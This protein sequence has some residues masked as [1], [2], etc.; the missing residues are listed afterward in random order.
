[1][2]PP[3]SS[4]PMKSPVKARSY[5]PSKSDRSKRP[6]KAQAP[7][8]QEL[9]A[10]M[11]TRRKRTDRRRRPA[12]GDFEIPADSD[13]EENDSVTSPDSEDANDPV[14]VRKQNG[15]KASSAPSSRAKL[16]KKPKN[17]RIQAKGRLKQSTISPNKA[18]TPLKRTAKPSLQPASTRTSKAT[19]KATYASRHRNASSN[20]ENRPDD[21][22][23]DTSGAADEDETLEFDEGE[24]AQ[25]EKQR[26]AKELE[27]AKALFADIDDWD[28]EFEDLS[29]EGLVSSSP[30]R[31]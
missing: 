13:A 28:M 8:T 16:I 1:M 27:K 31:R 12:A 21:L 11:P 10:L 6:K 15:R 25:K 9:Q 29:A 14:F 4:S 30:N 2:A 19:T 23:G 18:V 17:A 24:V 22:S 3:E 20:K 26:P 5:P 7:S